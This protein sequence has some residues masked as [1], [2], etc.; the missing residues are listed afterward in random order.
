[1]RFIYTRDRHDCCSHLCEWTMSASL[2]LF[3]GEPRIPLNQFNNLPENGIII[4]VVRAPMIH[5]SCPQEVRAQRLHEHIRALLWYMVTR[6][7][8][9]IHLI[10]MDI[11][12]IHI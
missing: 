4:S 7:Y 2:R 1:M 12:S 9:L 10:I 8:L 5:M 6:S 11:Q 3:N